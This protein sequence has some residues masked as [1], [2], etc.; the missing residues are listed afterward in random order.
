[1]QLV[2]YAG[3]FLAAYIL[4]TRLA[5]WRAGCRREVRRVLFWL[6]AGLVLAVGM[7]VY[8]LLPLAGESPLV[9]RTLTTDAFLL[10]RHSVGLRH[11]LTLFYPEALG[12]PLDWSYEGTELW[13]NVAY[14]G[15]LPLFLAVAGGA[16][17]R[18]RRCT[19]F[20]VVGFSA[21]VL[22]S[23]DTPL[24]GLLYGILP[25]LHLFRLPAR[26]LLL[27]QEY[28]QPMQ[29]GQIGRRESTVWTDLEIQ[30]T[31]R[32]DRLNALSVKYLLT[33]EPLK[34]PPEQFELVAHYLHQP[35]FR[36]YLGRGRT[37]VFIYRNLNALPRAFWV[38]RVM[39]TRRSRRDCRHSRQRSSRPRHCPD[40]RSG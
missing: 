22:L 31:I 12:T 39:H 4:G 26:L 28:L 10:R 15:L 7:T 16:L 23:L 38:E 6:S 33:G 25:G 19:L 20:L 30:G 27:C 11:L 35:F 2:Y 8:L 29:S 36:L 18:R 1:L 34:L 14:F 40:S 17:G 21:S 24:I 9:S 13:E 32:W 3:W 37:P 5:A